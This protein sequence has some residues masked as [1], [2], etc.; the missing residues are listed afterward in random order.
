MVS[1]ASGPQCHADADGGTDAGADYRRVVDL[2]TQTKAYAQELA[3]HP[4]QATGHSTWQESPTADSFASPQA[5]EE[6]SHYDY[7]NAFLWSAAQRENISACIDH[8]KWNEYFWAVGTDIPEGGGFMD[9][10]YYGAAFT[11]GL[12][13]LNPA[14]FAYY[15]IWGAPDPVKERLAEVG[16][17]YGHYTGYCKSY[18]IGHNLLQ[19]CT[20]RVSD[21]LTV[22]PM[23]LNYLEER[24]GN[25]M[26]QYGYTDY[27][28][29]EKLL[30]FAREPADGKLLVKDRVYSGLVVTFSPLVS[31]KTLALIRRFVEQGGKVIW[32][33]APAL[34]EADGASALWRE[35]F[36]VQAHVLPYAG[37]HHR[38]LQRRRHPQCHERRLGRHQRG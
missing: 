36:G 22:C 25:W 10:N 7:T 5:G 30:E 24:F 6:I 37:L 19:G 23:D 3:G 32:C 28:T 12:A 20:A 34:R 26:V 11:S 31:P 17:T 9:R 33:S 16:Q 1:P 13:V 8:F 18:D 2:C 15:C 29:E 14:A 4:I 27:I 38:H 21:V 35:I